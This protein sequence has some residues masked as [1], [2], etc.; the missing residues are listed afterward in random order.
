MY[1][2]IGLGTARGSGTNGY[3]QNNAGRIRP[4]RQQMD[5]VDDPSNPD[6]DH[7]LLRK[8]NPAI[9]EHDAKRQ[10]EVACL[11]LQEALEEEGVDADTIE[12]KVASLR[13]SMQ[14]SARS[15]RTSYI[16]FS[17]FFLVP[18]T[19]SELKK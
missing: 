3:V 10:I 19:S 16:S 15:L 17:F 4:R 6:K 11:T 7:I 13:A 2:G 5:L 9:L 12:E 18:F 8:A 14:A 1:N